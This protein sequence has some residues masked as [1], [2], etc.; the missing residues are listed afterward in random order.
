MR[1]SELQRLT[2]L[3]GIWRSRAQTWCCRRKAEIGLPRESHKCRQSHSWRQPKW[4]HQPPAGRCRRRTARPRPWRADRTR[5]NPSH[6]PRRRPIAPR[7]PRR[8]WRCYTIR[9]VN[10]NMPAGC[11]DGH[12]H[13]C[14][15]GRVEPLMFALQMGRPHDRHSPVVRGRLCGLRSCTY[16]ADLPAFLE[17]SGTPRVCSSEVTCRWTRNRHRF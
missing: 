7:Y 9:R 2:W 15:S 8:G 3:R 13:H 11:I 10:L 1:R 14:A 17:Q 6:N 5:G 12:V 4:R 16:L